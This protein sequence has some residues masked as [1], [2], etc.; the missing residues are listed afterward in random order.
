MKKTLLCS[1]IVTAFLT[2]TAHAETLVGQVEDIQGNTLILTTEDGQTKTFKTSDD[3]HY[4]KK[5]MKK[6]H[7][8]KRGKMSPPKAVGYEPMVEEDDWIELIYTPSTQ[9]LDAEEVQSITVY[10]D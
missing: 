7:K 2:T 3:T 4:R 1:L 6:E 9:Q 5:K 8:L 10:D